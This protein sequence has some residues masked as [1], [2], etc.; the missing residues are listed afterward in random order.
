MKNVEDSTILIP[1][2]TDTSKLSA[3]GNVISM[4]P[5][6][7]GKK[8]GGRGRYHPWEELDE[9]EYVPGDDERDAV[10]EY[11]VVEPQQQSRAPESGF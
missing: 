2:A 3:Y 10:R 6:I 4:S 8:D 1:L 9:L 5:A 7:T 11:R